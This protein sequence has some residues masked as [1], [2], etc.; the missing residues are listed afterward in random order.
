MIREVKYGDVSVTVPYQKRKFIFPHTEWKLEPK[1][2]KPLFTEQVTMDNYSA[3]QLTYY[4]ATYVH[5]L[6]KKGSQS[7]VQTSTNYSLRHIFILLSYV[8]F[9]QSCTLIPLHWV[10]Q[11]YFVFICSFYHASY[12]SN[13]S[14]SHLITVKTSSKEYKLWN[15][16]IRVY[17]SPYLLFH[18]A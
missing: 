7:N 10:Y 4:S 17:V 6:L 14:Q 3:G 13:T 15:F 1:L 2:L 11:Q 9:R 12:A 16:S 8:G 5:C 18:P